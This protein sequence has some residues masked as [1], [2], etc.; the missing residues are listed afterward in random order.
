[1]EV[2]EELGIKNFELRIKR[3][4]ALSALSALSVPMILRTLSILIMVK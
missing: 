1:M 3:A 4:H 2:G